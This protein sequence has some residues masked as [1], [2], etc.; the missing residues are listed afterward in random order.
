MLVTMLQNKSFH[1]K[2]KGVNKLN[3]GFFKA[4]GSALVTFLR[5]EEKSMYGFDKILYELTACRKR[6]SDTA[7]RVEKMWKTDFK[8]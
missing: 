1:L 7:L 4:L 8:K 6:L 2:R 5:S 3:A